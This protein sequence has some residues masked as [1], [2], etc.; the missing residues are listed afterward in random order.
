MAYTSSLAHGR[1]C[2]PRRHRAGTNRPDDMVGDARRE[3]IGCA[4]A[5]NPLVAYAWLAAE[6]SAKVSQR[7]DE[8]LARA[9]AGKR[10]RRSARTRGS[11]CAAAADAA[12]ERL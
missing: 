12:A 8:A 3:E 4:A 6:L 5:R 2:F 1:A 11:A 9:R 10:R 7:G